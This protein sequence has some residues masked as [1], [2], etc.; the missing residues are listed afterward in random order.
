MKTKER[1]GGVFLFSDSKCIHT[2]TRGKALRK[3]MY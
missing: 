2:I 3:H 1:V